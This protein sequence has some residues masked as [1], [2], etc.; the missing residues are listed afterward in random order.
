MK[1]KFRLTEVWCKIALLFVFPAFYLV[2]LSFPEKSRQFPQLVAAVSFVLTVLS[3]AMDFGR[4][5]VVQGEISGVDD[6]EL[7]VLDRATK[8]SRRQRYYRA[9]A[10]IIVSTVV[11]VLGGF[12]FSALCLVGG[13]SVLFGS[14]EHLKR[15]LLAGIAILAGVYVVFG[16]LMG[17][18][19][20]SG[21]LW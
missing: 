2:A 17:V 9:W 20:L 1:E 13:F 7:Q 14:R 11:G 16:E 21:V 15:N 6:T 18:P 5:S 8:Q 10:I 19:L 4:K 3:L 12:F